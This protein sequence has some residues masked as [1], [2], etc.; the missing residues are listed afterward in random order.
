MEQGRAAAGGG[1]QSLGR[2]ADVFPDA[3]ER[4]RNRR[5]LAQRV[6]QGG[7]VTEVVDSLDR[8]MPRVEST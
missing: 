1:W 6:G 2:V 7:A 5:H 3:A 8:P 4:N